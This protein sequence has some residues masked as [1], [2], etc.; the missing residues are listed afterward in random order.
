[1]A[2]VIQTNANDAHLGFPPAG[3]A[4]FPIMDQT[5]IRKIRKSGRRIGQ[6][7]PEKCVHKCL[8]CTSRVENWSYDSASTPRAEITG[9]SRTF[10]QSR[11][12]IRVVPTD[13][14]RSIRPPPD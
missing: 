9:L 2:T 3:S 13:R 6:R 7:P 1:M 5:E 11:C 8:S 10:V 4:L 14:P 12:N